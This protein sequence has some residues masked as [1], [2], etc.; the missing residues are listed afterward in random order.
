M[1]NAIDLRRYE[2]PRIVEFRAVLELLRRIGKYAPQVKADLLDRVST[3]NDE[4]D[5]ARAVAVWAQRWHLCDRHGP[6]RWAAAVG[7]DTS[8]H[9][10]DF[11]WNLN[12]FATFPID[13]P[14]PGGYIDCTG[15][16]ISLPARN[17]TWHQAKQ[18]PAGFERR[19]IA[20]VLSG[21]R[22]QMQ[23]AA[24]QY[25]ALLTTVRHM[26]PD[27]AFTFLVRYQFL[28]EDYSEIA[29]DPQ[30]YREEPDDLQK[31][32][33]PDVSRGGPPSGPGTSRKPP[34]REA[35]ESF[36]TT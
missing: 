14:L 23:S 22:A 30:K 19:V 4:S 12:T 7:L 32:P 33:V 24:E 16:E 17:F 28:E 13:A 5:R 9:A 18:S 15:I 8:K 27:R 21:V 25:R 1:S 11:G 35:T 20:S 31:Y 6:A 29:A 3:A 36:R 10:P 26:D 2:H 34:Q